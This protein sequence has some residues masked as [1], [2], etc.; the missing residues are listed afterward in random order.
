MYYNV[1]CQ[2]VKGQGHSVPY[3]GVD[4]TVILGG[5]HM[6]GLTTKVLL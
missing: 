4:L 2:R 5:R 1:Q 3:I 6:A